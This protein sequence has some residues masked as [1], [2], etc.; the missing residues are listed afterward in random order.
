MPGILPRGNLKKGE[1]VQKG[2]K[3]FQIDPRPFQVELAQAKAE[4]SRAEATRLRASRE[5]RRNEPL[6]SRNV[7][8][9]EDFE[10]LQEA[11]HVAAAD[12]QVQQARIDAIEL[13]LEYASIESPITGKVGMALNDIGT[14]IDIGPNSLLTTVH[15]VD[16]MNVRFYITEKDILEFRRDVAE[17]RI[18]APE[19]KDLEIEL[20]LADGSV[21][22]HKG[23]INF[24]DV[25]IDQ[26]TG[27]SIT[28]GVVPNPDG[29]L[30]PGQFVYAT[31]LGLRRT[32][33]VR[34]PQSAVL[35]SAVGANV[36]VVNDENVVESRPVVLGEWS[37]EDEWII[38]TGLEPGDRVV[39]NR[40]MQVRP[41][42]PVT[43][44]EATA[45]PAAEVNPEA[46]T[47]ERAA[48]SD[49]GESR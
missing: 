36:Y 12:V 7:I 6:V 46:P 15:Q 26:Q 49:R 30:I 2:Q 9:R 40:L 34:V 14:Y 13:Q 1:L 5:L 20:T 16:P 32:D 44:A 23:R 19:R 31:I 45:P 21:F 28:R 8:T 18:L 10:R 42:S 47:G 3:L 17:G 37:G 39:A 27:T 48:V 43:V 35:Q 24:L 41:G 25:E 11:E 29:S 33:V 4:L 38:E 22:P